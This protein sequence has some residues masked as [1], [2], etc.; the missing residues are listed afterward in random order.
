MSQEK[1]FYITTPI[2]YPSDNLHIGHAYTTVAADAVARFKR[3]T[4]YNV[5][6]LTGS[7]E[8][9]QKIERKAKEKGQSP[10]EYVDKIVSGFKHLWTELEVTYDDF[11]RTTE[12]R[13]KKVVQQ[14]FQKLYDQ[15]DIYKASY[16]GWYCTPCET[17][18]TESRLEDG[19]VCPD[20]GRPVELVQ[21]ES[22]F[23]RMSKYA[24]T[25]LQHIENNPE[26]I[27]PVSRHNEM[28]S[29]IKSGL[30]DLCVTRT[31]FDWGI[32]V[33]FDT[34][35]VAYVWVDAL[36]NYISA[37][38][39]N[40]GDD[41]LYQ[42]FWPADVHLVG[43]DIVRFHT[44]IWPIILL[45][46]GLPLPQKV[47]GHGWMLLDSGKMSKSKGNV[48][49]PLELK[50]KYGLDAV[51]YYLLR[52][53]PFGD[54]GYYSE[55]ALVHRINQDLANDLGNL[56]NRTAAMVVKYFDGV[57]QEPGALQGPDTE[58]INLAQ[59]TPQ[60][61]VNYMDN[62]EVSGAVASVGKLVNRVNKYLEE[63]SPWALAKDP[64]QKDRLNTV[65]YNVV[66]CMRQ[67]TVMISP[68]MPEFPQRAWPLLGLENNTELHSWESLV[69]GKLPGGTKLKKGKPLFPRIDPAALD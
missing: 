27:Q 68:F 15:G 63:T 59:D 9:G 12:E 2:Y 66:E 24:G 6:F 14:I 45:A 61:L 57:L 47:V 60:T 49:Y 58:L 41:S 55:E 62:M 31:T 10:Q 38:G 50:E 53:I 18:W 7:D 20:C 43:K 40:T 8:H 69:W 48:I 52:E 30:D 17:F 28:V 32:Q 21:E 42:K 11:I 1:T 33:P 34:D 65:L 51:R 13:H 67:I 26:F 56:F 64:G 39:Y 37:L 16:E 44:V 19:R 35:H 23:F 5:W 36:A 54:D 22:Y 3:A 25:L 29:F 4:G 46:L